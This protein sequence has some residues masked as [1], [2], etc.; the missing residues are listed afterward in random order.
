VVSALN[1][2]PAS[3][4]IVPLLGLAA[5]H[6]LAAVLA[7]LVARQRLYEDWI[8]GLL[9]GVASG[10]TSVAAVVL[11]LAPW[12]LFTRLSIALFFVAFAGLPFLCLAAVRGDIVALLLIDGALA[13]QLAAMQFPLWIARL[14]FGIRLDLA[15][16]IASGEERPHQF[17]IGQLLLLTA[18]VACLLGIA[19]WVLPT[20]II[21]RSGRGPELWPQVI[22]FFLLLVFHT[23]LPLPII[24]A[25]LAHHPR[26]VLLHVARI[27]VA[28][29]LVGA[30]T[31]VEPFTFELLL[32]PGGGGKH[33]IFYWLNGSH[34]AWLLGSLL[35]ARIS[36]YRFVRIVPT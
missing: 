1:N 9:I 8:P 30:L 31:F 20:D 7:S 4:R 18:G 32:P 34:A 13:A 35:I 6:V 23:V 2:K 27:F 19:K 15:D 17:G 11:A 5:A 14:R 3:A 36:G 24:W 16:S 29:V 12:R 26:G 22:V 25:A 10:Q 33:D 28:L 21:A